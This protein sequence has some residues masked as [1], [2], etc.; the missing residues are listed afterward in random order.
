M[1]SNSL[2][3]II[4]VL[5]M[6]AI[7]IAIPP[8]SAIAS[9]TSPMAE[10][11]R[12]DL[13]GSGNVVGAAVSPDDTR[14]FIGR[15]QTVYAIDTATNLIV[16][17]GALPLTDPNS[18]ILDLDVSSDGTR[19]F[20][21]SRISIPTT[22]IDVLSTSSL[23]SVEP[24]FWSSIDGDRIEVPRDGLNIFVII[25]GNGW[26]RL[27]QSSLAMT[28]SFYKPDQ[29]RQG[30]V[31]HDGTRVYG[32]G[33]DQGTPT[34]DRAYGF[35]IGNGIALSAYT[36]GDSGGGMHYT[37]VNGTPA[38]DRVLLFAGGSSTTQDSFVLDQDLNHVQTLGIPGITYGTEGVDGETVVVSQNRGTTTA[39]DGG[40][41]VIKLIKHPTNGWSM[42][43]KL[44]LDDFGVRNAGDIA[45]AASI[46]R[47]YVAN[48]LGGEVI[49]VGDGV[50]NDAPDCSNASPSK[51]SLSKAN[52]KMH[53]ITITGVT[54]PNSNPI[55]INIDGIRQDEAVV[56][57]RHGTSAPDGSGVGT[58]T[59]F[60]RAER[61]GSGD[62]RVY[63]IAF[64]ASDGNAGIC[65]G[66][67][68][69]EVSHDQ[70]KKV[71]AKKHGKHREHGAA[72]NSG[73]I[74]DS[75]AEA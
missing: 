62:G 2:I 53:E 13:P 24:T 54:D 71:D 14:L 48:V 16:A 57:P 37:S 52:Q 73:T 31:S 8:S 5:V 47:Y 28:A 11:T 74:Y 59:A 42:G 20:V 40:L 61:D 58:S 10:L 25:G 66:T 4:A 60:V 65:T 22:Q 19:L 3:A 1:K 7:A 35:K 12:I 34:L 17:T 56:G 69:V 29:A 38:D 72:V 39:Q 36:F 27:D 67:V 75:T 21:I 51:S 43:Q 70:G 49:V 18:Y 32:Q 50:Q 9:S 45:T 64:T 26:V 6:A 55:S 63:E 68:F 15:G 30:T 23:L 46:G 44:V 33:P 41:S